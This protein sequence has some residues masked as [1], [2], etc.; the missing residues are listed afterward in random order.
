MKF[1]GLAAGLPRPS[2]CCPPSAFAV[3]EIQWWHAMT[4]ANNE[5]VETLVEGIQREPERLQGRAGL[6]GHLSG[7]AERR[8]RRLPRQAAAAHP[9]GLRRRHRRDDGRRRRDQAGRRDPVDGRHDLRQE[10]V[11][12]RHRR[13]LFEA[14]RH[15]AVLPVQQLLADPLL[16]QGHLPEGRP[17]R[18]QSA[19]DLAGSLGSRAR[20]SRPAVR[21]PAATPRPG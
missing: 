2:P 6:Q 14:G 4:G 5:V 12:A 21:R 8:H 19:E 3:T 15:H 11:S 1:Q 18:R 9:A 20:R 13:L 10:P 17:R 7:D 16:Q